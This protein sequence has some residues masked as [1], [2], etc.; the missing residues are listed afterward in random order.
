MSQSEKRFFLVS[1]VSMLVLEFVA[2]S[3]VLCSED[4]PCGCP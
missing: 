3:S 4:L 2:S 1:P